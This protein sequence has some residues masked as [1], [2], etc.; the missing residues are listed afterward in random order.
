[1]TAPKNNANVPGCA[2][3]GASALAALAAIAVLL[4]VLPRRR[5]QT[6]KGGKR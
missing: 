3:Q 2:T 5:P 6:R 4:G 1:M